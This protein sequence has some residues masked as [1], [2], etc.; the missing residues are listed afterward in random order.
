MRWLRPGRLSARLHTLLR[1]ILRGDP[2]ALDTSGYDVHDPVP[3]E[4]RVEMTLL[5]ESTGQA[6]GAS[7]RG[8]DLSRELSTD[9]I[10]EIRAA[11]LDYHVLAF[12]DQEMSDDD[13]ERFTLYFGPFGDD[14]FFGPIPGRKHIAA[15]RRDADETAPVFAEVF[16]TDW[17]FQENPPQG[18]C[19]YS[20]KIP[21]VGGNTLFINQHHALEAMPAE[22]RD[23]LEGRQAIHSAKLGY[24]PNGAYG[25]AD[26]AAGRSMDIRPSETALEE[27][28][29]PIIRAHPE[30]GKLGLFGALGYI[31]GIEG[32]DQD[33]AIALL[34]E[35]HAWQ[36]RPE[37]RYEHEWEA[38]MLL[39]WDNRSVLHSATGGYDGHDRLLHRTTIGAAI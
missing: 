27:R 15:I 2:A 35:M 11:W 34:R 13:L 29:H 5:I 14:P 20:I 12:P 30:T 21:P 22:L 23:R 33:E 18:T 1:L 4:R 16:H 19:L 28:T 9:E 7:V 39:L 32:M 6:C 31:I 24:A 36:L 10:R 8:I 38:G 25:E 17:S 37:F 26:R 3:R